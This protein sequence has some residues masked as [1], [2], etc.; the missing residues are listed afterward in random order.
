MISR[1]FSRRRLLGLS[2]AA[3]ALA[4]CS[5]PA[6]TQAPAQPTQAPK[7]AAAEPTKPAAAAG[8]APAATSAP[9]AT[10]APAAAGA[11]AAG[12]KQVEIR[13]HMVK[14]Q[15][16]SDWIETA[17]KQDID[18]FQAKNP[19]IKITLEL[20]PGFA[21]E[22][23]PKILAMTAGGQLGDVTWYAP[24]HKS[25][26]G[27]GVRFK[28]VRDLVPLAQAANYDLK[29]FYPGALDN[30]TLEGKQYFLSYISEPIVPAIAY[31]KT[32]V[33]QLGLSLPTN[34]MTFDDLQA[35]AKKGTSG[36]TF[37]Y[38]RGS[39]GNTP[40]GGLSYLRQWGVEPV[41]KT[42][43][44]ATFLDNK[45]GFVGA[46][47]YRY[48]LMNT[49]KVS[50][51]T[52]GGAINTTELFGSGKLLAY[53]VWPFNIQIIPD[54]FKGK[55]DVDFFLA[56]LLKKGD[57]RR[58]GLNEHVFGV[59]TASKNPDEAFKV[60]TWFGS[61]ELNVQG[62]IQGQ[63]GPIARADFW[64]DGRVYEKYPFYKNLQALMDTIEADFT[65]A[66]FRG[67]DF[68]A[69]YAQV[70]DALELGKTQPDQAAA[71]IQKLCQAVLDKDPA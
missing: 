43:K 29:Q 31:N 44:K 2:L 46:L 70:F 25:Q 6:P 35:W 9:A 12:A 42:G 33:Q 68:D 45:D 23:I 26:I 30:N 56:P 15:D 39:S 53:D 60:V 10:G 62:V 5:A 40:F 65:V 58:S 7:P 19:N 24:R 61:K 28:V 18:G 14:K 4:A 59:T 41:D 66:N 52:A 55:I 54:T 32:K 11:P 67:E 57:K 69:T 3:V 17:M 37:G 49:W 63:K 22:F 8:A 50:P 36:D 71:D 20:V 51:T 13:A 34:D 64:A 47:K 27:W 38:F 1:T 16:V 21:A 48:D